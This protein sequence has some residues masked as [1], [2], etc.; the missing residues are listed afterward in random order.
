MKKSI[1]K[2]AKKSTTTGKKNVKPFTAIKGGYKEE[3]YNHEQQKAY[4]KSDAAKNKKE[5][6][7]GPED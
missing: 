6:T 1:E 3:V 7:A 4:Q 2:G 5:N